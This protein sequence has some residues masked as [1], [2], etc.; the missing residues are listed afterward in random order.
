MPIVKDEKGNISNGEKTLLFSID[1][2]AK[3]IAG[4]PNRCFICGENRNTKDFNDEHILP[5]WLLKKFKLHSKQIT[6]PNLTGYT[7]GQY[8]IPCCKDCNSLMAREFEDPLSEAFEK[9]HKGIADLINADPFNSHKIFIWLC[10]IFTKTH[11]KDATL[12]LERDK[13]KS[14]GSLISD[15]YGMEGLHHI[16]CLSR[17]FFTYARWEPPIMGSLIYLPAKTSDKIEQFDYID[18]VDT[19][20]VLIRIKDIAIIAVLEDC[21][22]VLGKVTPI[23][24]RIKGALSPI[25][26]REVFAHFSYC[27]SLIK[28]R[29]NFKSYATDSEYVIKADLDEQCHYELDT[30]EGFGY[31]LH[32]AIHD[33]LKGA[34]NYDEVEERIKGGNWTCLTDKDGNFI[35]DSMIING[36]G[37]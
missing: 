30:P 14:N 16:H 10:L 3:K 6:L 24:D 29:P 18:W 12:I 36:E 4:N 7:Y 20:S 27:S 33:I 21:G 26:L 2:F 15:I 8:V 13:R 32:S 23:L 31:Y 19:R 34:E 35:E 25:Q 1:E 22:A 9:G 28:N 37:F 11:L 5:N 17:T